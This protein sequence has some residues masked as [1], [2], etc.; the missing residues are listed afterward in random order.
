LDA[1]VSEKPAVSF[2]SVIATFTYI[3]T[4]IHLYTH[5]FHFKNPKPIDT[6]GY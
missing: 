6:V 2:F 3:R 1:D 5:T 4:Y